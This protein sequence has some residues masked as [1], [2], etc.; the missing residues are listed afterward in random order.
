[1]PRAHPP[2]RPHGALTE[3]LDNLFFVS[4]T[5]RFPGPIPIHISRNMVV[6]RDGGSLTLV[7]SVRLDDAGLAALDALGKVE[8]VVRL[9]GFHGSDDPFYKERYGATVWAVANQPYAAGFSLKPTASARYFEADRELGAELPVAGRVYTFA[10]CTVGEGLLVP[11][12]EG[13]V[14]ISGDVL[15]NWAPD[16]YFNWLGRTIMRPM[17]FF[18]PHNVGPGWLKQ[19]RPRAEELRGLLDVVSSHVLPAHGAPVLGEARAKYQ[20]AIEAAAT[21]AERAARA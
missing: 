2:A 6:V 19:A 7:N 1:M 15:Q 12:R 13:G 4:G 20:P 21:W 14:V 8:H 9:A 10:S 16:P 17:G 3:V 18:R 5:M 11:D